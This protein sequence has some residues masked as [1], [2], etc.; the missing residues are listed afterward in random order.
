VIAALKK[1]KNDK[2]NAIVAL[3]EGS[4]KVRVRSNDLRTVL[5]LEPEGGGWL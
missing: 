4:V 2:N 1:Y 5:S 3:M